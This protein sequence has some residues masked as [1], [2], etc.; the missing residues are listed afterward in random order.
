MET[1]SRTW[2]KA[3]TWQLLGLLVMTAINLWYLEDWSS[4]LGLSL[5][6]ATSGIMMFYLHERLWARI[7][8]GLARL[9]T[10][11]FHDQ[12]SGERSCSPKA[13]RP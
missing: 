3:L 1:K 7:E 5:I 4:S 2:M 13:Q 9:D 8:W 6:L 10:A 12:A 11:K